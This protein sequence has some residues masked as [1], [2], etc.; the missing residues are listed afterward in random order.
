MT[1]DPQAARESVREHGQRQAERTQSPLSWLEAAKR[2]RI[3]SWIAAEVPSG[4]K[5]EAISKL[6]LL[7]GRVRAEVPGAALAL[8]MIEKLIARLE[9]E[10]DGRP[11][12]LVPGDLLEATVRTWETIVAWGLPNDPRRFLARFGDAIVRLQRSDTGALGTMPLDSKRTV[13]LLAR[14]ARWG[15]IDPAL[16]MLARMLAGKLTDAEESELIAAVATPQPP[17]L[18]VAQNLMADPEMPLP[19]LERVVEV[20]VLAPDGTVHEVPGYDPTSRCFYAP[21]PG[22]DVPPVSERPTARDLARAR[23]LILEELLCDFPFVADAERASAV[24]FLLEPFVRVLIEGST[25]LYLFEAPTPGTG[26][27]LLVEVLAVPTLGSGRLTLMAEARDAD[28][29]RKR[30]TAKLRNAPAFLVIDNLRRTL[31]AG[32]L[33][34]TLTAGVVEDRLLGVSETVTPPVRCTIAATANNPTL[35]DEMTRRTVRIRLDSGMERPEAREGFR[36]PNLLAWARE[37]RGELI[38]AALTLARAWVAEGRPAGPQKP[39]GSFEDWTH[40]IGGILH[41]AG[42]KGLLENAAELRAESEDTTH[43]DLLR[44]VYVTMSDGEFSSAEIVQIARPILNLG[45]A[46]DEVAAQRVGTRLRDLVDRP[47]GGLVLRRGS[48]PHGSRRWRVVLAAAPPPPLTATENATP[49]ASGGGGGSHPGP[50]SRERSQDPECDASTNRA[51]ARRTKDVAAVMAKSRPNAGQPEIHGQ[52]TI[53]ECIAIAAGGESSG[54]PTGETG[55]VSLAELKGEPRLEHLRSRREQHHGE[56]KSGT[57]TR[58]EATNE[59]M[60]EAFPGAGF[61]RTDIDLAAEVVACA[62]AGHESVLGCWWP[63]EPIRAGLERFG[64]NDDATIDAALELLG[65]EIRPHGATGVRWRLGRVPALRRPANDRTA[66][67]G[68]DRRPHEWRLTAGGP[69][70][71][72]RCHPSAD[73]L[74]VEHR[75]T[76]EHEP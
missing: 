50:A 69:W 17:P 15:R 64:L 33:A 65:V 51:N 1:T 25:P 34:M 59:D 30:L 11:L 3:L 73:G 47:T 5:V 55:P 31:D 46:S 22:L 54:D 72:S 76:Q 7:D 61:E 37:N 10:P 49:G 21:A 48:N 9:A 75:I 20:P 16:L 19:V 58:A 27:T 35:S 28:E 12:L 13:N 24:A 62:L 53:D 36:H 68:C 57:P 71:C 39:I 38:W 63:P 6:K 8:S 14:V 41:V 40:V 32:A 74:D 45:D 29:W 4:S 18:I 26:K 42:I 23:E 43:A 44:A 60:L 52:M 67:C 56:L 2:E 70:T 66:E